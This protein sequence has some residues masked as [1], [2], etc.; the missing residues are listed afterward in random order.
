LSEYVAS[1]WLENHKVIE[2][3]KFVDG[4]KQEVETLDSEDRMSA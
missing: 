3:V 4:E 2:G 1:G